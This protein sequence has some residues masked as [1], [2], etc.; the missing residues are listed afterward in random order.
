[1]NQ[2][3]NESFIEHIEALR[4]TLLKCISS[5]AIIFPFV[6]FFAPKFLNVLTDFITKDTNISLNF[7]TPVEV[8][9]I[10]IKLALVVDILICFPYIVKQIWNFILPALYEN[11]K[12]FI[13]SIVLISTTL[14]MLGILFCIFL[15]LPLIIKFGMSFQSSNIQAMFNIT[16]IINL[17]LWLSVIFG[18]MFQVPLVTFFLIKT[19]VTEYKTI[20]DKRSYIIVGLLIIAGILTPPDVISQL[21]LAIPTYL[22]FESGLLCSK[23]IQ[24]K[25]DK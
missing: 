4:A 23:F 19:G 20:A 2:E 11:E 15:I 25:R 3:N 14:F 18:L 17:T 9:L 16:N 10:Q 6:F 12:K 7:F 5:I 13:K 8:F 1:M 24:K 22:L 21:M